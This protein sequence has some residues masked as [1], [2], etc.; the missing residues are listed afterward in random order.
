MTA[1]NT[2]IKVEDSKYRDLYREKLTFD[3]GN[4]YIFDTYVIAEIAEGYHFDWPS[5]KVVIDAVYEHFGTKDIKVSY[6][7]NRVNSYSVQPKDWLNFF[8]ERHKI[9]CIAIVAYSQGGVMSVVLEKIFSKAP[10]RKFS[11]LDD[12]VDWAITCDLRKV[13]D[14]RN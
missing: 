1:T 3:S 12:G 11:N 14:N 5:A 2:P 10:M 4:F 9:R 7:S 8:K 13:E 6:V